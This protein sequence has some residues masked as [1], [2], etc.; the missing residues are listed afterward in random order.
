[1]ASF[2]KHTSKNGIT[3][4][5]AQLFINGVRD[6]K[7]GFKSK[8][9]A[10]LW[11]ATREAQI[12]SRANIPAVVTP[13]QIEIP[14]V[15]K[16]TNKTLADVFDRY[17]REVSPTK[18]GARWEK[19]RLLSFSRLPIA[20]MQLP[21]LGPEH[22]ARWRDDRLKEV[23]GSTV[24]REM[25]LLS[26]TLE[27]ARR[28]W[29]WISTNPC[30]DVRKPAEAP[31]RKQRISPEE[32][33]QLLT[34]L[35]YTPGTTPINLT[36]E[37]AVTLLLAL[38][39]AMRSGEVL[40]LTREHIHLKQSYVHLPHT[41]NGS[42]RNVPLSDKAKE[43]LRLMLKLPERKD[44]KLFN[45]QPSTRDALFRRAKIKASLEH[46]NFHDSRRE[47]TTRLAEVFSPL[48][49][50]KITGHKRLDQLLTYYEKSATELAQ[51]MNQQVIEGAV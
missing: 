6:S 27:I 25:T 9:D 45:L 17:A 39:T 16:I 10:K 4:W 21:E 30:R 31:H 5:R 2:K 14:S 13:E 7:C 1:M 26:H 28:E 19:I 42:S 12:L 41:K 37:V 50:S 3:T 46:I 35:K 36:Q 32:L 51:K 33:Q 38:E 8:S 15:V 47:A 43:L 11:A 44:G 34:A 40:G 29:R 49:L 20:S 18:S 48:E 23:S 24:A 22:I